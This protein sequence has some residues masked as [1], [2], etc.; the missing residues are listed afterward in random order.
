VTIKE[1]LGTET[2]LNLIRDDFG[3][4]T[5]LQ[6]AIIVDDVAMCKELLEKGAS[7]NQPDHHGHTPLMIAIIVE[8]NNLSQIIELL[9][10]H[11]ADITAKDKDKR[12]VLHWCA[13]TSRT[14]VFNEFIRRGAVQNSFDSRSYTE[15]IHAVIHQQKAMLK[16]ML[17]KGCSLAAID[18][19]GRNA[20]H[21]A[22]ALGDQVIIIIHSI[23]NELLL[24]SSSLLFSPLLSSS[25]LFSPLLSSSSFSLS[26]SILTSPLQLLNLSMEKKHP[27]RFNKTTNKTK[28]NKTK[29]NKTQPN[30]TQPNPT[31][32]NQPRYD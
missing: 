20:L 4:F 16:C 13:Q 6:L 14:D 8:G 28:Q 12:T 23:W 3:G 5:I 10:L 26:L 32:P 7:P 2:N 1:L 15:L 29:Q 21:F 18:P 24:L 25:L 22:A 17:E 11:G 30:P 31:Q 27:L 19:W 9:F